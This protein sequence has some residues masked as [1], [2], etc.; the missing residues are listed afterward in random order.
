[1]VLLHAN[2]VEIY[3]KPSFIL[4]NSGNFIKCSSRS[5]IRGFDI[6]NI[7]YLAIKKKL[8][9]KGGGHSMAGGCRT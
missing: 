8:I 9:I 6:G 4:T 3:N 7:F 1:M 5:I 2:F